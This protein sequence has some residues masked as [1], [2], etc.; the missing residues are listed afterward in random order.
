MSAPPAAC[1]DDP[2]LLV[3]DRDALR[4]MLRRAIEAHGHAVV[5]AR[6][7]VEAVEA[8]HRVRVGLVLTDLRLPRGDGLDVLRAAKDADPDVPVIV[9]TASA[10]SRT[11]SRR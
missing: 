10:A 4:T 8:L 9:M 6:D 7:A 5:E 2:I 3:E 1:V 11:P